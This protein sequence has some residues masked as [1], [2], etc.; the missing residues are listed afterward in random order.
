MSLL[1]LHASFVQT[2]KACQPI[3]TALVSLVWIRE[4][5]SLWTYL[6]LLPIVGG[7]G[8]SCAAEHEWT[9]AGLLAVLVSTFFIA[10]TSVGTKNA[11]RLHPALDDHAMWCFAAQGTFIVLAP[12][13][14]W[15]EAPR[16]LYEQRS[17]GSVAARV[18]I[19]A[20]GTSMCTRLSMRVLAAVSP[21]S[22]AVVVTVKVRTQTHPHNHEQTQL[23]T[24][25]KPRRSD[26]F[27]GVCSAAALCDRDGSDLLWQL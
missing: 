12:Y 13:F 27:V 23:G 25:N 20:C 26:P 11:L 21:V 5:C 10:F 3:F 16:L 2:V 14:I 17:L 18:M 19:V 1:H 24:N 8:L 4:K 22:H 9:M 7:V 6:S 15:Q